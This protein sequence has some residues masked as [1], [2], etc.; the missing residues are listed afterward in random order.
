M[1][2]THQLNIFLV[3]AETLNFSRAAERLHLSQPSITQH[4]RSLE[5]HFG[6][7]LFIRSGHR[8]ALTEAG[9]ALVPLAREMVMLSVRTDEII[10]SLKGEVHG[11]LIV[12]CST[13]PGKYILPRILSNFMKKYPRVSATC[14]ISSRRNAV[15]ML[16][17]GKVHIAFAGVPE[18]NPDIE[19]RKFISEPVVLIASKDHP[20][21]EKGEIEPINLMEGSFIFREPDSGTY[22]VIKNGLAQIGMRI[23]DLNR[24]LTLGNSEAI[25][26]AVQEGIGVGFVTKI[27]L[28][29]MALSGVKTI[30]VK[31]LN[32]FQDIYIGQNWRRPATSA[33]IA[34]W[35]FVSDFQ[36]LIG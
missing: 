14:T 29:Q 19:F 23:D 25:A 36:Y 8:L 32:L 34:F 15:Q 6:L 20:W 12:G 5:V 22:C 9:S 27:V 35:N 10:G 24:V 17:D 33:Q 11:E 18:F 16:C 31:G 26:V 30:H 21:A 7:P 28:H 1:L 2:D 3:A 4:I 13:T